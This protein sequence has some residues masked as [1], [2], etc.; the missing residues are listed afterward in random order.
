MRS[1]ARAYA[2]KPG[3]TVATVGGADPVKIAGVLPHRFVHAFGTSRAPRPRWRAGAVLFVQGGGCRTAGM[4]VH[5]F[6]SHDGAN[7]VPR[8]TRA[9]AT[10]AGAHAWFVPGY[11]PAMPSRLPVLPRRRQERS[12][13]GY[14]LCT[15]W[16]R[17]LGVFRFRLRER[18]APTLAELKSTCCSPAS[19]IDW[20]AA[21]R[22]IDGGQ[23]RAD[24][25][26]KVARELAMAL[27]PWDL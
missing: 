23:R 2:S 17:P 3:R 12:A 18:R 1:I 7:A 19:A 24:R 22:D 14:S 10:T 27:P 4:R 21:H 9:A 13:N 5:R 8:P 16:R 26:A 11:A 20:H 25:P 15:P 6:A